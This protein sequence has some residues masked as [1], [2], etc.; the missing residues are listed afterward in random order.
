MF[1]IQNLIGF[2]QCCYETGRTNF[3]FVFLFFSV[4]QILFSTINTQENEFSNSTLLE[5][6]V[7]RWQN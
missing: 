2:L 3:L 6:T 1:H 4:G 5:I 7:N